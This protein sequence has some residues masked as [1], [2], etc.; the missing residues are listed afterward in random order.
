MSEFENKIDK[1]FS[2]LK[3]DFREIF[4][5]IES[6]IAPMTPPV[7]RGIQKQGNVHLLNIE[8]VGASINIYFTSS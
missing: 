5:S 4:E 1:A 6:T 8:I 3:A 7:I 2:D